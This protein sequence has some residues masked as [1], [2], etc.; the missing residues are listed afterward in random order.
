MKTSETKAAEESV[1]LLPPRSSTNSTVAVRNDTITS[2][3]S[4]PMAWIGS[5]RARAKPRRSESSGRR[6]SSRAAGTESP[7]NPS[8]T[9]AGRTTTLYRNGTGRKIR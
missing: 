2:V 1:I 7:T 5:A 3:A 9:T 4:E 6:F 8:Q